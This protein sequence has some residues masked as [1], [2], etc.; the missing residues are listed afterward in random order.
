MALDRLLLL[1][2]ARRDRLRA[3][4]VV[5]ARVRRARLL[6]HLRE[7]LVEARR[8]DDLSLLAPRRA[9]DVAL[10][11]EE[12]QLRRLADEP[13]RGSRV[14]DAGKLDDDLV[15]LLDADVG[16][17]DAELVDPALH[18]VLRPVEVVL[19]QLVA[20]RRDRLQDDLEAAL[21]VEAERRLLVDRAA[22]DGE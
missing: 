5:R 7:Q 21:Q 3:E 6:L 17:G 9:D 15:R 2:R 16:L 19:R 22:R 10:E 20:L 1:A 14:V 13:R 4:E 18:D 11:V 8:R 12:L